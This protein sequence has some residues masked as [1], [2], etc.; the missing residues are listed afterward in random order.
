MKYNIP[1]RKHLKQLV[2][3]HQITTLSQRPRKMSNPDFRPNFSL[4]D[5]GQTVSK[6]RVQDA[7]SSENK[8]PSI[9]A[10]LVDTNDGKECDA[11]KSASTPG[12]K[13]SVATK[14]GWST[15]FTM[16][17]DKRASLVFEALRRESVAAEQM[18]QRKESMAI[19][20]SIEAQRKKSVTFASPNSNS[21]PKK[22][23]GRELQKERLATPRFAMDDSF[24]S[25]ASRGKS[26]RTDSHYSSKEMSDQE[27][28]SMSLAGV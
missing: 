4:P 7:E 20:A 26:D 13:E 14:L 5:W 16:D 8:R 15:T 10:N 1:P 22:P 21:V 9:D 17:E 27:Q 28:R 24:T 25:Q 3:K 11:P 18:R 23:Q 19:E 12:R 2:C 6:T